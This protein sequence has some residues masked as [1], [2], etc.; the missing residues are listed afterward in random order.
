MRISSELN[1]AINEEIGKEL[2]SSHLYLSIASYVDALALKK[3]AGIL[4]KQSDEERDHAL[5]F[6][7]YLLDVDGEVKIPAIAAPPSNFRSVEAATQM[8]LDWEL[9][10]TRRI[11]QLMALAIQQNDYS[12][13]EFLKWFIGEQREEVSYFENLHK[14]VRLSGERSLIMI[15][16]YLVHLDA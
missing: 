5:K 13:Q 10:I 11:D 12:A 9:D 15:E 2:E 8:A 16:A 3:F 7:R 6:I 1:A 14:V 4:F